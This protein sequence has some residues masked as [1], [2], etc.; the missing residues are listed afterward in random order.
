[1]GRDEKL[2]G[3]GKRLDQSHPADVCFHRPGG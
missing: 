3:E 2:E 1:V